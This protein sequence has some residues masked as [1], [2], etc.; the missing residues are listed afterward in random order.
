MSF[1]INPADYPVPVTLSDE[2]V[3]TLLD[4]A[5]ETIG[6]RLRLPGGQTTSLNNS[7]GIVEALSAPDQAALQAAVPEEAEEEEPE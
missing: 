5:G 1:S 2:S 3:Y 6:P 7:G 4:P